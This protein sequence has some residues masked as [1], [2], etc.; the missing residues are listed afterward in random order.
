HFSPLP[1]LEP[2]MLPRNRRDFLAD[3]GR[4]MLVASV[5][6]AAAA[7]LGVATAW[8]DD[9][10]PA[11]APT[12]LEPLVTL[13]QETPPDKLQPLL[14]EKLS[15][16]TELRT[17]VAAGAVANARRCSMVDP[18]GPDI[19]AFMA[20]APAWEMSRELPPE[21]RALPVLKV[22]YWNAEEI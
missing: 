13:M 19:H 8:A 1:D 9:T 18:E 5:G 21:R 22:L 2:V 14:V 20:L 3:V 15:A 6:P 4:G 7:D 11:A 17:L 16:G 12:G 10:V